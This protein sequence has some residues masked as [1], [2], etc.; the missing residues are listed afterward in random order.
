LKVELLYFQNANTKEILLNKVV[1]NVIERGNFMKINSVMH[2][3]K[4][5]KIWHLII[6]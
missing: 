1:N 3:F 4:D 6:W 2:T 5:S